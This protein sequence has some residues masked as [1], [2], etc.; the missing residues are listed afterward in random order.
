MKKH[1]NNLIATL[2][3]IS[4]MTGIYLAIGYIFESKWYEKY[5]AKLKTASS[6]YTASVYTEYMTDLKEKVSQKYEI[7]KKNK[8]DI[9]TA[10]IEKLKIINRIEN[11]GGMQALEN[12]L[13]FLSKTSFILSTIYEEM[14]KAYADSIK[15]RCVK[16]T[17]PCIKSIKDYAIV[18]SDYSKSLLVKSKNAE[19]RN[20]IGM[21]K[22]R[23][24]HYLKKSDSILL[25]ANVSLN[26]A[27]ISV[28]KMNASWV[29]A[30]VALE[31]QVLRDQVLRYCY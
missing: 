9:K 13:P 7:C 18:L 2:F 6:V 24:T 23:T 31:D 26:K 28:E 25:S 5:M 27:G 19:F 14:A 29:K 3:G 11:L 8:S 17:P 10:E 12:H 20:R 16:Q 30:D 22:T 21:N 4:C 15:Y 1:I